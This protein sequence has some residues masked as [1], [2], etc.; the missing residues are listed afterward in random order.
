MEKLRC[1]AE[2]VTFQNPD[3]GFCV[4]KASVKGEDD[5]VPLVGKLFNITI[6]TILEVEGEWV[7]SRR[8]GRQFSVSRWEEI[9]PSTVYGLQRYLGS[10][11]IKGVGKKM[12]E[13]I[14]GTFG[15]DTID[16]IAS[17]D[18]YRELE[19]IP[20]IGKK[21]A[22]FIHEEWLLKTEEHEV[23]SFLEEHN[24]SPAFARKVFEKY[25]IRSI[26][27]IRQ[28][29]YRLADEFK[30][31]GFKLADRVAESLGIGREHPFRCQSGIR[32]VLSRLSSDEGHVYYP[33]DLLVQ[34]ASLELSV[35]TVHIEDALFALLEKRAVIMQDDRVYLYEMYKAEE[36]VANRI[37]ALAGNNNSHGVSVQEAYAIGQK[38][39]FSYDEL[40]AQ[41][42]SE[43][44]A[45]GFMVLTGGPG[46]GKT[47]T[48]QGILK[49][50]KNTGKTV[51]LAAPTGRAAKRMEEATGQEAKTIHRLLEYSP[52]D[53]IG[54]NAQKPL[55]GDALII[56]ESSMIDIFLM[57]MLL[58]AVPEDMSVLLVGDIDQL[59]SVGPG[60]ILRDIID[61]GICPVK[62]LT[63]IFRQALAS[64]IIVNAHRVNQGLS[65]KI[66]NSAQS[67][68]F[69]MERTG[70]EPGDV[71][72]LI[73]DL[74]SRRLP[75]KFHV[76]PSEIQVLSPTRKGAAGTV[77]L[78]ILLQKALNPGE[79]GISRGGAVY[80]E[81]DK[82]IQL[83]NDY[84]KGVFNGDI[85]I[86]LETK[87][88]DGGTLIVDFEGVSVM[89]NAGEMDELSHAYATTIHKSQG[90]EY[91]VV[92]MPLLSSH[93]VMLQ[94]NL[95]YT[96]I[97]RAKRVLV[98]VATNKALGI[99]IHNQAVLK[100]Y[101]YL[102]ERLCALG[103]KAAPGT[104]GAA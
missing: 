26:E 97:T 38:L 62:R 15:V 44:S 50:L 29:P 30:G 49:V 39:G 100:R 79:G 64:N 90:S 31:I 63:H 84:D 2:I 54:R 104:A 82:V 48:V 76:R 57:D 69:Y 11:A 12:A 19:K 95:L 99:A 102:T 66:D 45:S 73:V 28:N 87:E 35:D 7:M 43:A 24:V 47:T 60:N 20:N 96:G 25:G 89:Y 37:A 9:L 22:K 14:V 4:I 32:Y 10:G 40:Q 78:N 3:N 18:R 92:V 103:K 6:G 77:A 71:A 8:Y 94:R 81:G 65:L 52:K 70:W 41:A 34:Q 61:S 80:R 51:L 75:A 42:L 74:V 101:T 21:R 46:T 17:E 98:L 56:D 88:D 67:D 36:R 16:I 27:V 72:A 5:Y 33:K 23:R 1:V 68:F 55:E 53:G 93:Y 83:K 58:D 86:V 91:P 59:P 85:G 13:L